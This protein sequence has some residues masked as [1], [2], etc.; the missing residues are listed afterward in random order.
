[1]SFSIISAGSLRFVREKNFNFNSYLILYTKVDS[2]W[3][4]GLNIQEKINKLLVRN[5]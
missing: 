1:M 3:I 5:M 4:V 2:K